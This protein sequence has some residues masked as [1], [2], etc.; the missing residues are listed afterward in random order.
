M[1]L[2]LDT[3]NI[4]QIKAAF[5]V[6]VLHGVTTNPSILLKEKKERTVIIKE[7]LENSKG[8]VFV[9]VTAENFEEMYEEALEIYNIDKLRIGVK[10]PVNTAGIKTMKT[11]KEKN[12]NIPILATAIFTAEQG[13]MAALAGADYIAPYINRME[14]NGINSGDVIE[15]IRKIYDD[16]K[17]PTKILAASFKNTHQVIN[18]LARGAHSATISYDIFDAMINNKL[19]Q[20]SVNKFTSDWAELQSI[21]KGQE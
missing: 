5:E 6:G 20:D 2:Y 15:K 8:L 1:E 7:V 18:V 11:L 21:L 19:A 4:E 13:L 14:N 9:Q 12:K 16:G 3:A 10:I 17:L